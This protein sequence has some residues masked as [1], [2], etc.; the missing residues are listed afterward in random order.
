MKHDSVVKKCTW[1]TCKC[2]LQTLGKA[3]KKKFKKKYNWFAK[4]GEKGINN[5]EIS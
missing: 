3:L 5:L 4:E 2:V 1:I